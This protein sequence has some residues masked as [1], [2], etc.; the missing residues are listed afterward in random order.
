MTRISTDA[1]NPQKLKQLLDRI[2]TMVC[3]KLQNIFH[4]AS[5]FENHKLNYKSNPAV[6]DSLGGVTDC[7]TITTG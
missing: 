4:T 7:S 1:W 3:Q 5:P 2:V 6:Q